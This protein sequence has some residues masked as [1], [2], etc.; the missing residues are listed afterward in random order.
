MYGHGSVSSN[1]PCDLSA[2]GRASSYAGVALDALTVLYIIGY[3]ARPTRVAYANDCCRECATGTPKGF[4]HWRTSGTTNLQ[5]TCT[6]IGSLAPDPQARWS[7]MGSWQRPH[8][9]RWG[10]CRS[11][12]NSR[13]SS[14]RRRHST[15]RP[16]R[17]SPPRTR[18]RTRRCQSAGP[19]GRRRSFRSSRRCPIPVPRPSATCR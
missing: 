4:D 10:R 16:R 1:P 6:W 19:R 2:E 18:S 15:A 3:A 5:M 17:C 14:S 13:V 8:R 11:C 9:S 12:F 7:P